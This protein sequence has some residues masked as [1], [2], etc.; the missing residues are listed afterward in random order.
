M[1][2]WWCHFMDVIAVHTHKLKALQ[3]VAEKLCQATIQWLS[4]CHKASDIS[5]LCN[6]EEHF[7]HSTPQS[8]THAPG[9]V[10]GILASKILVPRTFF[11][12]IV[13]QSQLCLIMPSE[14]INLIN[15]IN[16][17]NNII[18]ITHMQ[19]M[20]SCTKHS[21]KRD[22]LACLSFGS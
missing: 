12:K 5:L 4:S 3:K 9:S 7:R 15:T 6:V 1:W 21:Y 18:I 10:T 19:M 20:I 17:L 8:V 11:L 16:L 13:F 2:L 14:V 22:T